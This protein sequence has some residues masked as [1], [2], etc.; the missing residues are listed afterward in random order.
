MDLLQQPYS[1]VQLKLLLDE[2]FDLYNRPFYIETDPIQ[3]PH[4]F[5][6]PEDIEIAAFLTAG[7]AWGIRISIINN[8]RLLMKLMDHSP[9]DFVI[10]HR[11]KDLIPLQKF[12]HRTFNGQDCIFFIRALKN[13][14]QNHGGLKKVF[15]E[16]FQKSGDIFNSLVHFRQLF[17]EIEHSKHCEKHISNVLKNAAAK[18]LN[19]FLRWMI[20][21]DGRGVDFGIWSE[22]PTAKLYIPLDVHSANFGRKLGLLQRQQNDWKAVEE[23]TNNLIKFDPNDP[24][25]YDY[26]LFGMGVF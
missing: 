4:Q 9:Y 16:S 26:A 12:V 24:V 13:I 1:F 7:I 19:L 25:K 5:S 6:K 20:R 15:V 3:I 22:I 8:A 14:Y 2:K 11:E 10:N 17:F 23:L 18:R 21:K